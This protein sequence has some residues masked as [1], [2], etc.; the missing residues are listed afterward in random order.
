MPRVVSLTPVGRFKE[1]PLCHLF[2]TN[3]KWFCRWI[4]KRKISKHYPK[5]ARNTRGIRIK[6]VATW[7]TDGRREGIFGL[8]E[9]KSGNNL[10]CTY[11]PKI[12]TR[13]SKRLNRVHIETLQVQLG[14]KD[15]DLF[16]YAIQSVRQTQPQI[17]KYSAVIAW[18]VPGWMEDVY[19]IWAIPISRFE[20]GECQVRQREEGTNRKR[21]YH[22][23]SIHMAG[24]EEMRSGLAK[25]TSPIWKQTNPIST[26]KINTVLC[27]RPIFGMP[28]I[29][30]PKKMGRI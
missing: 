3:K 7:R 22:L 16:V 1:L 6:Q 9:W 18:N 25:N 19:Y 8:E 17:P 12:S 20:H 28:N 11:C 14:R 27:P 2:T 29:L 15:G 4:E 26:P 30:D 10:G 24:G 5:L 21:L 13:A 23:P